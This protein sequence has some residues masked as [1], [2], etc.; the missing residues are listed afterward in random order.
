LKAFNYLP[1]NSTIDISDLNGKIIQKSNGTL[2]NGTLDISNLQD[3]MYIVS[4]FNNEQFI[5]KKLLVNR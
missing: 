5:Y 1:Q 2:N 4:I 3:G